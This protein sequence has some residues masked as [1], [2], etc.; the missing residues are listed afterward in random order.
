MLRTIKLLV[1]KRRQVGGGVIPLEVP[2]KVD[3]V[4]PELFPWWLL[5]TWWLVIEMKVQDEEEGP[6]LPRVR[7]PDDPAN[8]KYE[9]YGKYGTISMKKR[10]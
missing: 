5:A 1:E 4:W 10:K 8:G 7:G 3:S 9:K 2:T 6:S